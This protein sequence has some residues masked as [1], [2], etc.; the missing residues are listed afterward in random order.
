MEL[1]L[2]LDGDVLMDLYCEVLVLHL[3][4]E[5][6]LGPCELSRR[7]GSALD[8]YDAERLAGELRHFAALPEELR[9]RVLE[10]DPTLATLMERPA[11]ADE[12]AP[13]RDASPATA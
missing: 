11:A 3:L 4:A 1:D 7:L 6:A 5:S 9:T 13:Q 2:D 8:S 12:A 10:G